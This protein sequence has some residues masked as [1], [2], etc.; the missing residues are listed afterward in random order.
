MV[1]SILKISNT[2]SYVSSQSRPHFLTDR[3]LAHFCPLNAVLHLCVRCYV[4]E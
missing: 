3:E 1:T 4:N 2:L